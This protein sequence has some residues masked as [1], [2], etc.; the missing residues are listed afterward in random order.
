LRA[1]EKHI[2][3]QSAILAKTLNCFCFFHNRIFSTDALFI[4]GEN[5]VGARSAQWPR[6]DIGGRWTILRVVAL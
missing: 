3:T 6:A 4:R 5:T 2:R 1:D